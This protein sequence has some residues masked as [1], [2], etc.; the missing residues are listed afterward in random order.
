[1]TFPEGTW[2]T[3]TAVRITATNGTSSI[4][5]ESSQGHD[6]EAA[7]ADWSR[8]YNGTVEII[9][10]EVFHTGWRPVGESSTTSPSPAVGRPTTK[11]HA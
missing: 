5:C 4:V 11:D 1:M 2:V 10:R 3:E 8:S 6:V 7:Y 9:T